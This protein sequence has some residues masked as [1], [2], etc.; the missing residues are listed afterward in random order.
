MTYNTFLKLSAG[1]AQYINTH[2]SIMCSPSKIK[3]HFLPT[4]K[5]ESAQ[6]ITQ[7][8]R[9][10]IKNRYSL[11]RLVLMIILYKYGTNEIFENCVGDKQRVTDMWV[12]HQV[13]KYQIPALEEFMMKSIQNNKICL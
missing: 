11:N 8:Y 5:Y 9:L 3:E 6:N 7:H 13:L 12:K 1:I 2:N 10:Y 4:I